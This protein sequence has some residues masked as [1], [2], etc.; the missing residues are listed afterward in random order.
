MVDMLDKDNQH[1]FLEDEETDGGSFIANVNKIA[2]SLVLQEL[3][4]KFTPTDID[5][6]LQLT[7]IVENIICRLDKLEAKLLNN[8]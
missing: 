5:N 7:S 1:L 8:D 6:I 3:N 2:N 4:D